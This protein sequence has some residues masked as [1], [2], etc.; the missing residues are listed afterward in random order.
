VVPGFAPGPE[1]LDAIVRLCRGLDGIPLALELAAARLR[2]LSLDELVRRL[3]SRF[4]V[5]TGGDRSAPAHHRS[6]K[7]LI[8]WSYDQLGEAERRLFRRLSVFAGSFALESAEAVC[9][10]EELATSRVVD[11]LAQ[12]V[13]RSL[14]LVARRGGQVRYHLLETLRA[15]GRERLSEA[16]EGEEL[17]RRHL[18][19]VTEAVVTQSAALEDRARRPSSEALAEDLPDIRA[20]L[21][22]ASTDAATARSGLRL[23]SVVLRAAAHGARRAELRLPLEAMLA[24]EGLED[25]RAESEARS[26]ASQ[27]AREA[28]DL[29]AAKVHAARA[30]E[31]GEAAE[32]LVLQ[33]EALRSLAMV[34]SIE[35]GIAP[36]LRLSREALELA[37]QSD[38][39]RQLVLCHVALGKL[40]LMASD[41]ERAR[42]EFLRA[43]HLLDRVPNLFYE[44]VVLGNLS[45]VELDRGEAEASRDY[46]RRSAAAAAELGDPP[47]LLRADVNAACGLGVAGDRSAAIAALEEAAARARDMAYAEAEAVCHAALCE[48]RRAI[49][50]VP[51]AWGSCRDG[52]ALSRD[53]GW[54]PQT[55]DLIDDAG[56]LA[57]RAGRDAE[58][59]RLLTAA[60]RHRRRT[61]QRRRDGGA[62]IEQ[63][64]RELRG[65]LGEQSWGS[66]RAEGRRLDPAETLSAAL[67]VADAEL[68]TPARG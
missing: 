44:A 45:A 54:Q 2:A 7:A 59:V 58:A 30:L 48:N 47:S 53:F 51:G 49:D 17:R 62:W 27:L 42:E 39:A 22:F 23:A 56:A 8:D 41:A 63:L 29:E 18:R 40:E 68:R 38:Q 19:H 20:A 14:V 28:G 50:D 31:L 1:N 35:E 13:D 10:D 37:R 26:F 65:R 57:A 4:D 64:L 66:A 21:A 5:L 9:A 25:P 3:D 46:V 34:A 11:L 60:S 55:V 36:A 6:L 52:L 43:L 67:A 12:L 15:Y 33:S 32:D 24:V 61:G 16:G